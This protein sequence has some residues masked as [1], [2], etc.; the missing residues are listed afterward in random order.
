MKKELTLLA[1]ILGILLFGCGRDTRSDMQEF[2]KAYNEPN[3]FNQ[4]SSRNN[5]ITSSVATANYFDKIIKIKLVTKFTMKDLQNGMIA[6]VFP[7]LIS[8]S[9]NKERSTKYLIDH[10]VKFEV[11]LY[12]D[13]LSDF[14][15]VIIDKKKLDELS[16]QAL[17]I[18]NSPDNNQ[19]S[20]SNNQ[21]LETAQMLRILNQNLP[22][23]DQKTGF[24]TTKI[25]VSDKNEVLY[26]I[27]VPKKLESA[28]A[29]KESADLMK[30]DILRG[31]SFK[32]LLAG[33]RILHLSGIKY[34]C[35]NERGEL[36][37]EIVIS[38]NH[39]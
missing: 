12:T 9:I 27:V 32:N 33:V 35:R 29:K 3:L 25:S 39:L 10:G 2:V 20:G 22:V 24:K 31:E 14:S 4:L 1:F 28:I 21:S 18:R 15:T 38:E 13:Q 36:L 23:T 34:E 17:E 19:E 11:T 5:V 16:K 37:N 26:T 7:A 30:D 8:E 6:K